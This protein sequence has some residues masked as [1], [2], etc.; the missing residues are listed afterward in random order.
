MVRRRSTRRIATSPPPDPPYLWSSGKLVPWAEAT[1]HVSA[2]AWTGVSAVFEGI[3]AYW[4]QGEEEMYIFRL[5]S[6]LHRLLDS[7]KL[8]RMSSPYSPSELTTAIMDLLKAN[9]VREDTYIM[10]LAYFG[11][12]VPGYKA[13]YQQPGEVLIT[14]RP[15]ASNA[16]SNRG[17]HC[18]ISSW[19]RISDNVMSP[20]AKSISNYQNSRLVSTE[21][22]I[23]G[24]DAGIILNPQGKVAEGAYACVFLVRDGVAITPGVTAGILEGITRDTVIRLFRDV[25][26]M[27]VE[28]RD[29]DR[30]E[31]YVAE[32][33]F[34][35]GTYFEIEPIVSVDRYLVGSGRP[36][37]LTRKL[38]RLYQGI[39]RGEDRGYTQWQTPVWHS[40]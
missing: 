4:N 11:G 18:C 20:R 34:F 30:T 22:Q 25:L 16:R 23:N 40:S 10:P 33:A 3:R 35:C 37:P 28:E 29:V 36:G 19:V 24:Y 8:M 13:A 21:A 5:Q 2:L 12:S 6:H 31:L 15:L 38:R 27:P 14:T 1:V 9:Q 32:E 7:M 26:R 39:V 17:S